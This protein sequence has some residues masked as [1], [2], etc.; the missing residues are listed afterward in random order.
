MCPSVNPTKS[1]RNSHSSSHA[2]LV[3]ISTFLS[4]SSVTITPQ[5]IPL[6]HQHISYPRP[7]SFKYFASSET[8]FPWNFSSESAKRESSTYGDTELAAIANATIKRE[9]G[10]TVFYCRCEFD[11]PEIL[12]W[13]KFNMIGIK[14][15]GFV[16]EKRKKQ[17][18]RISTRQ[19][20]NRT[21]LNFC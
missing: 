15:A 6:A 11:K 1:F 10:L 4:S 19:F 8:C 16:W 14:N 7:L 5:I 3:A 18:T 12:N 2:S 20:P 13:S 17:V 9:R 21:I